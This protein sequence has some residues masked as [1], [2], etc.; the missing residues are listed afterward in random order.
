MKTLRDLRIER[1]LEQRTVARELG[2]ATSSLSQYESGKRR[3]PL[4]RARPLAETLGCSV[5]E[6]VAAAEASIRSNQSA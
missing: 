1:N 4:L 2:I 5:V 6:V 3:L